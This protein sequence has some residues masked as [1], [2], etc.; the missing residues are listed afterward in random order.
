[1]K[2][3]SEWMSE[4]MDAVPEQIPDLARGFGVSVSDCMDSFVKQW[5]EY[6]EEV[7]TEDLDVMR[8]R[9]RKM[10]FCPEH[11]TL[12]SGCQTCDPNLQRQLKRVMNGG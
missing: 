7:S 11:E 3:F 6:N 1:M 8:S 5:W 4:T 10:G 12:K 9:I 2:R